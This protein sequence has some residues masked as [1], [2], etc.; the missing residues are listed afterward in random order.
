M[1]VSGAMDLGSNGL[2][3]TPAGKEGQNQL[4]INNSQPGMLANAL[5]PSIRE[6][7]AAD[8]RV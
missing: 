7:E 3:L 6:A 1:A 4:S 5:N 8:L 2:F